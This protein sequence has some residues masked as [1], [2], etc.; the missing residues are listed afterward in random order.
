MDMSMIRPIRS[1]SGYEQRLEEIERYFE[2][3]PQPETAEAE[4]FI[5]VWP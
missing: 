5:T 4:R 2:N 1:E 3:E